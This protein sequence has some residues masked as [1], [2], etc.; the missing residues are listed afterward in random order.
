MRSIELGCQRDCKLGRP[1]QRTAEVALGFGVPTFAGK[2]QVV[3][4]ARVQ[5]R[6]GEITLLVGP[7]GSGKSSALDQISRQLPG[8]VIVDRVRFRPEVAIIDGV[9]LWLSIGEVMSL[10]T[11]CGLSE[12]RLWLR[13]FSELS[14]GERFRARLA[15][16]VALHVRAGSS[17]PLLCDEFCSIIH[18]R[19]AKA[20]SFNLR[21]LAKR[22]GLA[23]VLA[24]CMDD[25]V[26]DL[27]PATV[28]RFLGNGRCEVVERR[29]GRG[30][31]CSLQRRMVISRGRARDYDE[32]AAMHY[33][34]TDELGFVDKVFLM[35]EGRRGDA[36]GI[37]VYAFSPLELS[38]RN[39]ATEGRFSRNPQAVNRSFRILRRLVMHPDVRGCGLGH[40]LV[41]KTLP[42]VGTAYVECLAA[43]GE[44]SPVFEKAGMQRLGQYELTA[45]RQNALAM[46][47]ELDVDP[48]SRVFPL[49]VARRPRVRRIVASV[50]HRWYAS[51]IGGGETRAEGQSAQTLAHTFR[52]LIG[53]RPVYYLW[54]R[55]KSISPLKLTG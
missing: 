8:A 22:R 19:C 7:S 36:V 52:G 41:K 32:F 12:P 33:R 21:K 1:S 39:Q 24:S 2:V 18:R 47:R 42:L 16:A 27:Q 34:A 38:F 14:D 28:V 3:Q 20:I 51:T 26:T 5:L 30:R 37:V 50:V 46:L 29:A 23:C 49:Q 25:V 13:R 43:M 44:F 54:H 48:L 10:L 6:A 45:N 11:A 31:I 55:S 35:R 53:N 4:P 15:R 9:A 17:A 40:Y